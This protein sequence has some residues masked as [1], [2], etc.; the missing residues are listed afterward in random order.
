M[1][2]TKAPKKKSAGAKKK[3]ATTVI[4]VVSTELLRRLEWKGRQ[5]EDGVRRCPCCDSRQPDGHDGC[6]LYE[7]LHS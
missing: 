1:T 6:D 7:V 5:D 3:A 2:A 4:D